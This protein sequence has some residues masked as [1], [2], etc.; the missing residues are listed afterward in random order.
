LPQDQRDL[1]QVVVGTDAPTAAFGDVL[2]AREHVAESRLPRLFI[3]ALGVDTYGDP[4]IRPLA[5]SVA[6][7]AAVVDSL[8][9]HSQGV[10]ALDDVSLL[11]GK[12]VTPAE[13]RRALSELGNKLKTVAQPDD[14]LL[15]FLAGHGIVDEATKK[16]YFVGHDF[17]MSDFERG[18]YK[19]CISWDD[20]RGL[21]EVPCRKLALLDTCHS[22]AIQPP[23]SSD[24]KA[25]VRQL[26]DD[27]IFTVTAS[28]G[29][30]RSAEKPSWGH[31]AFTKCLLEALG[32]KA[33]ADAA[34]CI[35]LDG[36][37][38]YLKDT[39]PK[40]TD[41]LQTPTAAPDDILP[42]TSL[43]LVRV[44]AGKQ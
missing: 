2:V 35:T 10:Y 3:V 34:G 20:F 27:V 24:L 5:F 22:G 32:G 4:E 31:G 40:L 44:G 16:Y 1:I 42:F 29:D 9:T 13:F 37:V 11:T 26:Q 39:V 19:D 18:N 23:R 14:V 7:A 25:A 43:P 33:G 8:K 30:Q 17:T 36:L 28:T 15:F 38:G 41:G 12:Q 21:A 6:D